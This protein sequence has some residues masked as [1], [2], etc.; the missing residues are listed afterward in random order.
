MRSQALVEGDGSQRSLAGA[1]IIRSCAQEMD[2]EKEERI[3]E[4]ARKSAGG[5]TAG[6]NLDNSA[7]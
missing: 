2:G 1:G 7:D 5:A 3:K 4:R 6:D